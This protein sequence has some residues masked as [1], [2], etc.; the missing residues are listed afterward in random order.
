MSAWY[1]LSALGFYPVC[2]GDP[3]YLIGSPLFDQATLSLAGG[4]TFT[5]T[6]AHNGPQEFYIQN[7]H[8]NGA[9]LD[10]TFIAHDQIINGGSLDFEMG[11][12]PNEKWG[13]STLPV[14]PLAGL[15]KALSEHRN[16]Q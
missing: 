4:K 13:V 1:V 3:N 15:T 14:S 7:A 8:L 16:G 2:P 11:S 5:V 6:A 12:S 9:A 10:R